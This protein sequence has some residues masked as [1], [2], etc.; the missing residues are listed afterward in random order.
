MDLYQLLTEI[1][2]DHLINDAIEA[3]RASLISKNVV[4]EV[5]ELLGGQIVY[6][7]NNSRARIDE[8]HRQILSDFTGNNHS[9]VCRKYQITHAWLNKLINRNKQLKDNKQ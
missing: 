9:D 7:K 1:I 2:S 3:E 8:K 5:A 4:N 6:L